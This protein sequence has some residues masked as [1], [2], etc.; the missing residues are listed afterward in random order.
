MQKRLAHMA[1]FS[2]LIN[3]LR[4]NFRRRNGFKSNENENSQKLLQ[5]AAAAA[6]VTTE[7]KLSI[8]MK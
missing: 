3:Q 6:A 1:T 8:K 4:Q 5:T 2:R 7:Q